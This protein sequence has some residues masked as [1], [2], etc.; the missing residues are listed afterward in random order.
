MQAPARALLELLFHEPPRTTHPDRLTGFFRHG[1]HSAL[2]K[3]SLFQFR[4]GL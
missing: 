3:K 1:K 2:Q 4:Q